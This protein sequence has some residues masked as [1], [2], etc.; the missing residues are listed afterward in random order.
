M[1]I[2]N[3]LP[4]GEPARFDV[5]SAARLYLE[6]DR[7]GMLTDDRAE[8]FAMSVADYEAVVDRAE[9]LKTEEDS[10]SDE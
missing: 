9:A 10:A 1:G 8:A 7:Q 4:L 3:L 5:E 2:L 6:Y